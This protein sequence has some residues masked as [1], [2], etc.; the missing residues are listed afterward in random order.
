EPD[1]PFL[2]ALAQMPM[3]C[4]T[5]VNS[6]IGTGGHAILGGPGDGVVT[7]AS[8][9]YPSESELFVDAKHEKLQRDPAT[10]SEVA[11]ILR[12]HAVQ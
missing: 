1:S 12:E 6:I 8:A 3:L 9:Q 4:T 7:V 11:R 5:H 10:I 2:R